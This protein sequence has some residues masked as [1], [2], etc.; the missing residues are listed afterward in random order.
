MLSLLTSSTQNK[1]FSIENKAND[2]TQQITLSTMKNKILPTCLQGN[3]RDSFGQFNNMS[4]VV[5]GAERVKS[6]NLPSLSH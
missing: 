1:L 4:Y 2:H 6:A 5:S 3:F